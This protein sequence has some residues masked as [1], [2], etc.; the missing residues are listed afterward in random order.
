ML[1]PFFGWHIDHHLLVGYKFKY[2]MILAAAFMIMFSFIMSSNTLSVES[3]SLLVIFRSLGY[4]IVDTL[5]EGLMASV[6]SMESKYRNI[7]EDVNHLNIVGTYI[8]SRGFS[9][10]I[11]GAFGAYITSFDKMQTFYGLCGLFPVLILI[12][13]KECFYEL[14][15]EEYSLFSADHFVTPSVNRFQQDLFSPTLKNFFDILSKNPVWVQFIL[16]IIVSVLPIGDIAHRELF[17]KRTANQSQKI[18]IRCD[19]NRY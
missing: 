4:A 5:G 15:K 14:Q 10:A 9:R 8:F 1:K 3:W 2:Y 17:A 7:F 12:F 18:L 13:A 11:F 16:I 19:E 6:K